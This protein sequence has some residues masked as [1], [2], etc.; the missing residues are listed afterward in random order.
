MALGEGLLAEFSVNCVSPI[1]N[2]FLGGIMERVEVLSVVCIGCV[3]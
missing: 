1:Q 3:V 2:D